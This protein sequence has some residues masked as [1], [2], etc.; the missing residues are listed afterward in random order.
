[1]RVQNSDIQLLSE[2]TS[3]H[4]TISEN[5]EF[6]KLLKSN[7]F[8]GQ[9]IDISA[10]SRSENVVKLGSLSKTTASVAQLLL[11]HPELKSSTWSIIHNDLNKN[12]PFQKIPV[13]TTIYY[14]KETSELNWN[15]AP[16]SAAKAV[17]A[18]QLALHKTAINPAQI[19]TSPKLH[20]AVNT[21]PKITL[22]QLSHES[23]N[24]SSL[25]LK[26]H[27][28]KSDTWRII[29]APS[30]KDKAFT[31]IPAGSTIYMDAKTRELS[32][33]TAKDGTG[34]PAI[35]GDTHSDNAALL[36]KKLDEAVKP[37]MG[38]PYE[39]IDCYTLVVHGLKKMGV[40]YTGQDSLSRQLLHRAKTE[41]RADNAYFTG[42]GITEALGEKVYSKA[43]ARVQDV[44]KQSQDIFKEMQHLMK[45]GDILSFSLESKGHTGVI[46]HNQDQWTY[47]NS[48]RLDNSIVNNAPRHGVGEETLLKEISNW[49]KLAQKRKE[50][51]QITVGRL[52]SQK[53][54]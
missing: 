6:S 30:N 7:H 43:I 10:E 11:A 18:A 51:L 27:E 22:G 26:N 3:R 24:I 52:D 25:L 38:T 31:K 39:T 16:G 28:L 2:M 5:N 44:D 34:L 21:G 42:E 35:A 20:S 4:N 54:V 32:W 45:K 14:N 37:Y 9:K 1:M 19:E 50:P 53:L 17:P 40:R 49:V 41:G 47:I 48:G 36:A 29:H 13:G 8:T 23:P 33:Q 12:K 46:S 15:Q